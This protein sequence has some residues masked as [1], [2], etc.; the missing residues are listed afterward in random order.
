MKIN[1]AAS[2]HTYA[3]SFANAGSPNKPVIKMNAN[4]PKNMIVQQNTE[5]HAVRYD[6]ASKTGKG[7]IVNTRA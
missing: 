2:G 1:P 4:H 7:K 3:V 5:S 6:T